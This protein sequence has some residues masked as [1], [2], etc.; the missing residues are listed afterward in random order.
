MSNYR[1][2]Y[3]STDLEMPVGDFFIGRSSACHLAVD[4]T[5]VSRRHAVFHVTDDGVTVEDLGSRNGV[6]VNGH[7]VEGS[8]QV[9]HLDRITI[10]SQDLI[11]IEVG[12]QVQAGRATQEYVI[13]RSCGAPSTPNATKCASC[14]APMRPKRA[15]GETL[16]MQSPFQSATTTEG[17][18]TGGFHLIAGIAEKALALNRYDEVERILTPH[19]EAMLEQAQ[20]GIKPRDQDLQLATRLALRLAESVSGTRWIDWTFRVHGACGKL[21]A[22]GTIDRLYELVRK[23]RYDDARQLRAYLDLVRRRANGLSAA[24]RFLLKR[25]EGLERVISA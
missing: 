4:D 18:P 13:C 17:T 6:M 10:G 22:A 5:L 15:T 8:E 20:R 1:L 23:V 9:E 19:L 2:R 21:M 14:G 12:R 16:E 11:V 24:E 3:Q 25:L 7:P